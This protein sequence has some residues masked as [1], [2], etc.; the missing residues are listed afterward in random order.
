MNT[1]VTYSA[2][3][4]KF[5]NYDNEINDIYGGT[6][7]AAEPIE[8]D[9]R[10]WNNRYGTEA[11]DDLEHFALNFYFEHY[12]DTG[13]LKYLTVIYNDSEEMSTYVSGNVLTVSFISNDVKISGAPNNGTDKD[14][15]NYIDLRIIFNVDDD[16]VTLKNKDIKALFLEVIE[17][18]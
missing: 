14:K 15:Q 12:E 5:V 3:I 10:V 16:T 18:Q 17:Q 1:K 13:L 2:K 6:Y 9:V 4:H 7:T 8:L 11:V